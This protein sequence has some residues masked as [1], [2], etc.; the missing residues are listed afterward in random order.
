MSSNA[1][2]DEDGASSDQEDECGADRVPPC[3]V[4]K[5]STDTGAPARSDERARSKQDSASLGPIGA[6]AR[7]FAAQRPPGQ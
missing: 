1:S 3:D 6:Q 2:K 4:G 7:D 5:D